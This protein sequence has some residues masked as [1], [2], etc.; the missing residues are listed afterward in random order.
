MFDPAGN[1]IKSVALGGVDL[2]DIYFDPITGELFVGGWVSQTV[3]YLYRFD[4]N[5]GGSKSLIATVA[6]IGGI[7]GGAS[8]NT[9]PR[10]TRASCL[11]SPQAVMWRYTLR[12]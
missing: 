1:V 12:G 4:I 2:I 6:G 11:R 7:T 8:G 9:R 5:G 10:S 3:G